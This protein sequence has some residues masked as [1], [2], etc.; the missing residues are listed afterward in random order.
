MDAFEMLLS[1]KLQSAII[2]QC[3]YSRL[4]CIILH[5]LVITFAEVDMV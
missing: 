5:I 2:L 1:L 3:N 4:D